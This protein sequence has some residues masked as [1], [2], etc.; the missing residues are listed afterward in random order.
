M[1]IFVAKDYAE[2]SSLAYALIKNTVLEDS[3]AVLGLA[4]GSTPLGLYELMAEDCAR[5]AISY[6]N[7]RT[8]N[9]DEY[10]GL[11][12]SHPQ[13]YR[14][15]MQTNLF[16]RIDLLQENAFLPDGMAQD[17]AAECRRY[18][19]LLEKMPRDIQLLGIGNNGHIAFNEPG[20]PFD[21]GTH[22]VSLDTSTIEANARFFASEKEVPRRAITMG[23]KGIMS[24]KKV[25]LVAT[26][27]KKAQALAQALQGNVEE[28][29]P[30]SVLQRHPDVIVVID[31]DASVKLKF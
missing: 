15:F 26:G 1:K 20:T 31:K 5:G 19:T 28:S 23:I 21:C 2:V 8:A 13:S 22:I 6:K 11:T 29:C 30:A 9:L 16:D 25:L 4:T 3:R 18:D 14:N 17:L 12:P 24:A 10:V 7:V 27:T